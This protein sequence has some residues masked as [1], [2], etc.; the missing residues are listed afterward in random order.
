VLAAGRA[1]R[2]LLKISPPKPPPIA[3]GLWSPI[4]LVNTFFKPSIFFF[5]KMMAF[6]VGKEA[7]MFN[8]GGACLPAKAGRT[9]HH[10]IFFHLLLC[11][12]LYHIYYRNLINQKK[13]F[14]F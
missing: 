2:V 12:R 4:L 10:Y 5:K 13:T 3:G 6:L 1:L 14:I 8:F 11:N 9:F 7:A